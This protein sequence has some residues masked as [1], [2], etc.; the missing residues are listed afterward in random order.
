MKPIDTLKNG[1]EIL[2]NQICDHKASLE[3]ALKANEPISMADEEWLDNSANLADE[4]RLVNELDSA[5]NYESTLERLNLQ[6]RL[7]VEKLMRIA[8][9]DGNEK[10]VFSAKK[11]SCKI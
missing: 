6:Y 1:L 5:A 2:H 9:S 10:S 4:E 3:A 8:I 7:T 11:H